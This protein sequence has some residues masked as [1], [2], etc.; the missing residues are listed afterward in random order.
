MKLKWDE[1]MRINIGF[2][3]QEHQ[4]LMV[5]IEDTLANVDF[6]IPDEESI[7]KFIN[8]EERMKNHFSHE[9]LLMREYG[10]PDLNQHISSH[11][12]ILLKLEKFKELFYTTGLN[13]N[14]LRR[15]EQNVNFLFKNHLLEEDRALERFVHSNP[16]VK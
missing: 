13:Q 7:D 14:Q 1:K 3:D 4:E 2:M 6:M 12:K 9:E 10:Y 16:K 8:L 15:I 11:L 5:A